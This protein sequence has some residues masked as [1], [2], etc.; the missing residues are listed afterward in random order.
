[1]SDV[2]EKTSRAAH[3]LA[4]AHLANAVAEAAAADKILAKIG[5]FTFNAEYA[6]RSCADA[7]K[8]L[9]HIATWGPE[10]VSQVKEVSD[11]AQSRLRAL[12]KRLEEENVAALVAEQE[13][14]D[15][16]STDASS[17]FYELKNLLSDAEVAAL[18][19]EKKKAKEKPE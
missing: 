3:A 8:E 14:I 15:Q 6:V 17:A 4:G 13:I 11:N 10:R 9:L 5:S 16:Q 19:A 18:L 2:H 12:L 1:M 7:A